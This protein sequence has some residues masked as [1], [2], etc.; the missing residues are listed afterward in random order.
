MHAKAMR[1]ARR[2]RALRLPPLSV[3][4][5]ASPAD[6]TS[7]LLRW[8]HAR[9]GAHVT[10]P[11]SSPYVK[12]GASAPHVE[13]VL[14]SAPAAAATAWPEDALRR[15]A[16]FPRPWI[17]P[18]LYA[19]DLERIV[20]TPPP[21]RTGGQIP[22]GAVGDGLTSSPRA[23]EPS[24]PASSVLAPVRDKSSAASADGALK[25]FLSTTEPFLLTEQAKEAPIDYTV[26]ERAAMEN[27][28]HRMAAPVCT[29]QR[30]RGSGGGGTIGCRQNASG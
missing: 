28:P 29:R 13:E 26:G 8:R 4:P 22:H 7:P 5:T 24:P 20:R 14:W 10:T 15:L 27:S 23:S 6:L 19:A 16:P 9:S 21:P 3:P 1:E 17:D 18:S 2:G 12:G 30:R 11:E 25:A